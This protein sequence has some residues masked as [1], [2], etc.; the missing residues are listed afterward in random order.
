LIF[1]FIFAGVQRLYCTHHFRRHGYVHSQC[2]RCH[3][4]VDRATYRIAGDP[5]IG[6]KQTWG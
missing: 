4:P 2:R 1:L 3:E 5:Q 6:R